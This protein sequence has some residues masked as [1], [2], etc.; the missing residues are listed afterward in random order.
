M[1]YMG[2]ASH[3]IT[4]AHE[5]GHAY[6]SWVMRDLPN[7]QRNYGMSLAETA[8]TFGENLVRDALLDAATSPQQEFD[9]LWADISAMSSFLINI[10]ARYTF[11]KKVYEQRSK[12]GLSANELDDHMSQAW[13]EWYGDALSEPDPGFW[14]SKL[15]FFITEVS[16]YNF[17]YL[18]GYLFS[19]GVFQLRESRGDTFFD[20]YVALLRDTGRMTAESLAQ[21]HLNVDLEDGKFWRSTIDTLL[22][23]TSRFEELL[24][25]AGC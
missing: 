5:L 4:L 23:K 15:H 7:A 9:I 17:P 12:R 20:D 14:M 10:P 11:E 8:S 24:T 19:S 6:H 1:T 22:A 21:K 2:R 13:R 18:F 16:F 25:Q 3:V